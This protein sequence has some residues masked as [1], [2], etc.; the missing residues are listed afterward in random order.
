MFSSDGRVL[1]DGLAITLGGA[2]ATCPIRLMVLKLQHAVVLLVTKQAAVLTYPL[3]IA[4]LTTV[5][6]SH[7][8]L[9]PSVRE[10]ICVYLQGN[11]LYSHA[12]AT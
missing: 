6:I 7:F 8:R 3:H 2:V 5:E 9:L 11:A 12:L 4:V 1:I 10:A